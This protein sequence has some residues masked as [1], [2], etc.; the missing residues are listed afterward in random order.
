MT[1]IERLE[2]LELDLTETKRALHRSRQ[3]LFAS[4][5]V[6]L[7]GL[8]M[9]AARDNQ[10]VRANRFVVT[11][12]QGR[13]R[14]VLDAPK[15]GPEVRLLDEN[16]KCRAELQENLLGTSFVL[17]D[18]N[19]NERVD[20]GEYRNG[21]AGLTLSD[22]RSFHHAKFIEDKISPK[23]ILSDEN[24]RNI[25]SSLDAS[26]LLGP[27][28]T[29]P[30][31]TESGF[32]I[33]PSAKDSWEHVAVYA[34]GAAQSADEAASAANE[35]AQDLTASQMANTAARNAGN[36]WRAAGDAWRAIEKTA[37]NSQQP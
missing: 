30:T 11:D 25:W 33:N 18:W 1:T 19:G 17:D 9:A 5:L 8:S 3:I 22:Q 20:I 29:S 10:E 32:S 7:G 36:A 37:D 14:I 4:I 28:P 21:E 23:L 15:T 35:E 26:K 13:I 31:P 27:A 16:G 12:E 6:V 2:R 34:A 24:G